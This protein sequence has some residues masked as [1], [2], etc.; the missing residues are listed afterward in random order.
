MSDEEL[1]SRAEVFD[2][3]CPTSTSLADASAVN[4]RNSRD[5]EQLLQTRP[6]IPGPAACRRFHE[7]VLTDPEFEAF[8]KYLPSSKLCSFAAGSGP[9]TL[10]KGNRSEY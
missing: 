8:S 7:R 3:T 5:S 2:L 4:D 9:V 6:H 10:Q 1:I